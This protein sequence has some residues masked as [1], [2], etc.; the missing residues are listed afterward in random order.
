MAAELIITLEV[1]QDLTETYEWYEARSFGLGETFLVTVDAE[2]QAIPRQPELRRLIH[3]NYRRG[4]V[5]R[6]P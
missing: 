6:F 2:I 3:K 1:E 5:R 4:L